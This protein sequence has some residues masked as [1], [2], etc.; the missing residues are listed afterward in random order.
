[1]DPEYIPDTQRQIRDWEEERQELVLK[2]QLRPRDKDINQTVLT[3]LGK[4]FWLGTGKPQYVKP[5]VRELA[6]ITC[7]TKVKGNATR[8]RHEFISGDI[9]F[10]PVGT[11]T[12]NQNPHLAD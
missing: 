11:V 10:G 5:V 6:F 8:R 9:H 2:Q 12:S 7:H 4:L 3:V 1:L